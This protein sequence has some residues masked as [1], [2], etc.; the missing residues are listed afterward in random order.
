MPVKLEAQDVEQQMVHIKHAF[1]ELKKIADIAHQRA[2]MEAASNMATRPT[3]RKWRWLWI[4]SIITH[5]V[6]W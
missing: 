6:H 1:Q 3:S 4:G 2:N 5:A